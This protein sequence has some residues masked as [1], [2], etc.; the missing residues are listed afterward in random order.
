MNKAYNVVFI[1]RVKG[2][3]VKHTSHIFLTGFSRMNSYLPKFDA[4]DILKL[5]NKF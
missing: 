2:L 1:F 3:S 4:L 5:T